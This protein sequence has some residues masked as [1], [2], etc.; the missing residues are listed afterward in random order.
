MHLIRKIITEKKVVFGSYY[1]Q[2]NE[3][4]VIGLCKKLRI[5]V[6]EL[7]FSRFLSTIINHSSKDMNPKDLIKLEIGFIS[8]FET[9][10]AGALDNLLGVGF[11]AIPTIL[12]KG[13]GR[14]WHN[15]AGLCLLKAKQSLTPWNGDLEIGIEIPR[16]YM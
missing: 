5:K 8:K 12:Q 11:E 10:S 7:E 4:E 2:T 14:D 3:I 13:P 1:N 15:A 9:V 6:S 16:V